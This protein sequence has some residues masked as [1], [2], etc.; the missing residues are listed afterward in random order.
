MEIIQQLS[1]GDYIQGRKIAATG[2]VDLNGAVKKGAGVR[3][4]QL[5]A[6]KKNFDILIMLLGSL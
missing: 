6:Q 3:Q 5:T 2:E 4:K 1:D